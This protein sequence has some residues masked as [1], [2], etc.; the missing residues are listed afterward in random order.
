MSKSNMSRYYHGRIPLLAA[1]S[2]K[3]A[4]FCCQ[5]GISLKREDDLKWTLTLPK[6]R[7]PKVGIFID[8]NHGYNLHFLYHGEGYQEKPVGLPCIY[9]VDRQDQA[10]R[11]DIMRTLEE[12]LN[13]IRAKFRSAQPAR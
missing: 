3:I 12:R 11:E 1:I 10:D 8:T 2:K 9:D 4:E 6:K 5:A 7:R 13:K